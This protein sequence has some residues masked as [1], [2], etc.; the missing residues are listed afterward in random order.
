ML[1]PRPPKGD[2][3]SERFETRGR[4]RQVWVLD[5]N[6][7]PHPVEILIGASDG[8]STE[9][10]SGKLKEGDKVIIEQEDPT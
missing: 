2:Q 8:V 7:E 10:A 1:I 4:Q 5:G 9:V 6:G 3:P